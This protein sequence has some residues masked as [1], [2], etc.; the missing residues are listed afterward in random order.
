MLMNKVDFSKKL[1]FYYL[2]PGLTEWYVIRN[3]SWLCYTLLQLNLNKQ[4][5]LIDKKENKND[6]NVLSKLEEIFLVL[7]VFITGNEL[8]K[9]ST[10]GEQGCL[11]FLLC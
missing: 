6:D 5:K 1:W 2:G 11:H 3:L 8:D 7:T 10:N 9:P 4:H